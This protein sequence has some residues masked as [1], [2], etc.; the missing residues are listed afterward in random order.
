MKGSLLAGLMLLPALALADRVEF[1]DGRVLTGVYVRDEGIRIGIWRSLEAVARPPEFFPR[2]AI[3]SYTIERGPEWDARPR[4]PDLSVTFIELNPKLAGLHGVVD[5]DRFSRPSLRPGPL[6]RDVGPERKYLAPDEMA[7]RL[8]LAYE[9]GETVS[10]TAHV[11]NLGFA[12]APPFSYEWLVDG[13]PLASGRHTRPLPPGEIVTFEQKWRWRDGRH[14]VTFRVRPAGP[15]ISAQNDEATDPLWGMGLIF[16]ANKSRIEAWR[17]ARTAFGTFSFEDYYRWHIDLMNLLIAEARFPATPEGG[18]ARVRLD[19]IVYADDV[20]D[21]AAV[22]DQV[23]LRDGVRYDQGAWIWIDDDDRNRTWKPPTPEWRQR[24]E[25]SLPHELGHQLGLIDWY[26]TDY[27]GDENFTW[28]DNGEKISHFMSYPNQ[29]MH[30]H[31]P[32]LFGEVDVAN[33]NFA[34]GKPRGYYGE[35]T[36]VMPKEVFVQIL[37]VNGQPVRGARVE[38]FQRGCTVEAEAPAGVQ[39]GVEWFAVVED[40]NFHQRL[41][42]RPVI[43][44]RTDAEGKM[45]LPNRPTERV[46]TLTGYEKRDNPF[47]NFDVVGPRQLMLMMV[48][49]QDRMAPFYIEVHELNVRWFRGERERTI[50]TFRGPW[51]SIDG[52]EPPVE[53]RATREGDRVTVTWAPGPAPSQNYLR[54][55]IGYRVWRRSTSDALGTRPWM[56]VATLGPDARSFTLDLRERP[57]DNWWNSHAERVAISA[58]GFNGRDSALV[59]TLVPDK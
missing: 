33:L 39:E 20:P 10:M 52:P 21:P 6:I 26:N 38:L 44:G 31:G 17:Q 1:A 32:H 12:P 7:S 56:P 34:L 24:T 41:S 13:Q 9:P 50:L 54:W 37:D 59:E 4:L 27:P 47:G 29:M 14:T 55:V 5:Y 36:W 19:R 15:E 48:T 25:W 16:I 51:G 3:R 18:L 11:R 8:K 58:I 45:R 30:W 49:H 40:G 23:S 53:V 46:R 35:F 22:R 2:S 57:A 28:P 43:R 42:A